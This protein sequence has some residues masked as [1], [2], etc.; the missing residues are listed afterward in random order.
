MYVLV[1]KSLKELVGKYS[2]II[3]VSS[4][5]ESY[6]S[7]IN[8]YFGEHKVEM[9]YKTGDSGVTEQRILIDSAGDRHKVTIIECEIDKI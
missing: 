3:G 5:K 2:E 6:E 8:E 4:S 1:T 9:F 7:M